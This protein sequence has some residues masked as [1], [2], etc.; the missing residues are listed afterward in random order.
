[1][2]HDIQFSDDE[3]AQLHLILSQKLES[4][5]LELH[6]TAGREYRAYVKQRMEQEEALLK[7]LDRRL[8]AEQPSAGVTPDAEQN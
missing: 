6:H 4:S 2:A 3:L 8:R 1:M 5:R 7:K